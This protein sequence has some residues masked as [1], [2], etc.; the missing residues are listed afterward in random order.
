MQIP[1]LNMTPVHHRIQSTD[2]IDL[3][4]AEPQSAAADT[5]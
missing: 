2:G 3:E 4:T 1:K 5:L